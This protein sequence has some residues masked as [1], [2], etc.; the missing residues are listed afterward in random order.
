MI[1]RQSKD[2]VHSWMHFSA[3]LFPR[4]L[5][6]CGVGG[7][8]PRMW[9][10]LASLFIKRLFISRRAVQHC[11]RRASDLVFC[12]FLCTM[13]R[14]QAHK[15]IVWF[16]RSFSWPNIMVKW[17]EITLCLRISGL[18]LGLETPTGFVRLCRQITG[19]YLLTYRHSY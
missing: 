14:S 1:F 2:T 8:A 18:N 10:I 6:G 19:C 7:V 13:W 17:L 3:P 16:H 11:C 4:R 9:P 15:V 12:T 5:S